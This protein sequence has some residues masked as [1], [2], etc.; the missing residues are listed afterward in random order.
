MVLTLSKSTVETLMFVVFVASL[1]PFFWRDG[2]GSLKFLY[3]GGKRLNEIR[4]ARKETQK[5]EDAAAEEARLAAEAEAARVAAIAEKAKTDP[6]A[7]KEMLIEMLETKYNYKYVWKPTSAYTV[8][9]DMKKISA[10]TN[11]NIV[12]GNLKHIFDLIDDDASGEIDRTELLLAING[13]NEKGIEPNPLVLAMFKGHAALR[14]LLENTSSQDW[15]DK[16]KDLDTSGDGLIDFEEF[17]DFFMPYCNPDEALREQEEEEE[18]ERQAA[19]KQAKSFFGRISG[20]KKKIVSTAKVAA[21]ATED[22]MFA[23]PT[24]PLHIRKSQK[25]MKARLKKKEKEEADRLKE[26]ERKVLIQY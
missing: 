5:D 10:I 11:K 23:D 15:A 3:W 1:F 9:N 12:V 25:A 4:K 19:E 16:F 8:K 20:A 2:W 7:E 6:H 13:D 17:K 24:V 26:E 21:E 14:P 22:L 18:M